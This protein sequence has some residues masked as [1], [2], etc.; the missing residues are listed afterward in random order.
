[1]KNRNLL[2]IFTVL[3]LSIIFI[4]PSGCKKDDDPDEPDKF[5][6]LGVV[7]PLDQEKGELRKNALLTAIDEINES[8]GVGGGYRLDLI[9]K[10]SEGADRKVA[11]AVAAEEIIAESQYLV[12]FITSFSSS[13]T[14]ILEEVAIPDHFP[15][16]SGSATAS[17]LTG[18]SNYFQRLCPPDRFEANVLATQAEEY[19]INNVAIA[20]EEGDA[21]S[22][23]L[24]TAFQDAFGAGATTL[25]NFSAGDP[26]YANKLN[27]LLAG[28][29]E[30]IFIS[31]LNPTV[32]NEFFTEL[33]SVNATD[34][35]VNTTFILCDGLYSTDLFQ[36]PI[37]YILGEVNGHPKNFGAFPS[38]DTTSGAY[39]Y[40]KTKLF[41]QYNQQ[42]ASYNAQFY[43]IGF[44]FA[45]AIEKTFLEMGTDNMQALKEKVNDYIRPVSHGS[46]GDPMVSPSQGW[47][48]VKYACQHGGVDYTGA[49]GNCNIDNE[50]NAVTP[51][52]IFQ[53]IKPGGSLTFEIIKIIP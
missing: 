24:A 13:T 39:I 19:G 37:D 21:Y 18:V 36:A 51:Y 45:M 33:G 43:D 32:Y 8:G 52:S 9:I 49:S 53:V 22:T 10:S 17:S 14:G 50:G 16:L 15:T 25:V 47:K 23:E 5:L 42:V 6:T 30:G 31:M 41:Q 27:Q 44:I 1:M 48:S 26:D 38:A 11:A 20:V 2:S 34:G 29:P 46:T 3:I 40:F 12:G 35:L 28:D 7:L 4:L